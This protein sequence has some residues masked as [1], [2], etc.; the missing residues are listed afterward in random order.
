MRTIRL[1]VELSLADDAVSLPE[2]LYITDVSI[3]QVMNRIESAIDTH[4][5]Y[6]VERIDIY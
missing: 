1:T 3:H 5:D 4:T 6:I 2:T